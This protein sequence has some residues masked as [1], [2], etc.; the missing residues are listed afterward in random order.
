MLPTGS[1]SNACSPVSSMPGVTNISIRRS[2]ATWGNGFL[3]GNITGNG[4]PGLSH[5]E[6]GLL[7]REIERV[8]S[9][10]RSAMSVQSSLVMYPID[11]FGSEAQKAAICPCWPVAP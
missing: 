4:C 6:Y 7:A 11:R 5:V 1:A 9:G 3:G 10:Y 2:C 8:D